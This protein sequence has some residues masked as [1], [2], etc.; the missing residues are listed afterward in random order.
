MTI[1]YMA[2]SLFIDKSLERKREIV[3]DHY[4][5]AYHIKLKELTKEQV[6]DFYKKLVALKNC[7]FSYKA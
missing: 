2:D 7:Q 5:R 1:I 3:M 4:Q 6:E